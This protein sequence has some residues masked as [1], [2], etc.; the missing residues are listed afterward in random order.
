MTMIPTLRQ[1]VCCG[2]LAV[3]AA[4]VQA[5]E[6]SPATGAVVRWLDKVSGAVSDLEL[7]PGIERTEGRLTILLTE[8]R[9]PVGDPSSNA[10]AYL[11]IYDQL[12]PGAAVF[13][14]WM[15]ADSPALNAM[16]HSRYDLWV[17]RCMTSEAEGTSP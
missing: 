7:R 11:T 17:L 6:A 16:D 2:L 12:Y 13:E 9:Y 14:G 4:P 8:C 5:Q 10:Y 3:M 1:L 15:V